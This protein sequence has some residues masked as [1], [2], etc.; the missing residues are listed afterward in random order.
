MW[1]GLRRL[2]SVY[3]QGLP[4]AGLL[5]L[6]LGVGG[7]LVLWPGQADL[8]TSIGGALLVAGFL[9]PFAALA[10]AGSLVVSLHSSTSPLP[11][12][13]LLSLM[14]GCVAV[15]LLGPGAWS[16]DAR[17]FGRREIVIPRRP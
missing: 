12:H 6:R 2:F 17:L 16:A 11:D 14:G 3:P 13:G 4:G 10:A 7:V 15:A 5:L 9:T 1:R 8:V